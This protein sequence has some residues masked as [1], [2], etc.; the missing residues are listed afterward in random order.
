MFRKLALGTATLT[1]A[2]TPTGITKEIIAAQA[3]HKL[4]PKQVNA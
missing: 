2:K 3:R 1:Y 4:T